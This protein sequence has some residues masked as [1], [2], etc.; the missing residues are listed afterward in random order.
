MLRDEKTFALD[1]RLHLPN[2]NQAKKA[3][4]KKKVD[5]EMVFESGINTYIGRREAPAQY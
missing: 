2:D 5:R 1:T 4:G 3:E